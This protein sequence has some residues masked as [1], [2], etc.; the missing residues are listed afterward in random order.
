M[1]P[2][3]TFIVTRTSFADHSL[4]F[5]TFHSTSGLFLP[6]ERT[7]FIARGTLP[8]ARADFLRLRGPLPLVPGPFSFWRIPADTSRVDPSFNKRTFFAPDLF[9]H[10]YHDM[11]KPS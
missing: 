10:I 6:H 5:E 7:V 11:R 3:G 9:H 2:S 4:R 1:T 8:A